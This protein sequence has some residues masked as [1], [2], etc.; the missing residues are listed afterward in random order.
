MNVINIITRASPGQKKLV[1]DQIL[2]SIF[3]SANIVV[4]ITS[5]PF[6]WGLIRLKSRFVRA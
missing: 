3:E 2:D 5:V 6:D 4:G 1:M